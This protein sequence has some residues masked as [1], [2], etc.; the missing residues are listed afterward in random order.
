M[1]LRGNE[2][3]S[4]LGD[5][6]ADLLRT[7]KSSRHDDEGFPTYQ[8]IELRKTSICTV[9][10]VHKT[11]FTD[12]M[13]SLPN[14]VLPFYKVYVVLL[15][16]VCITDI[17]NNMMS[18]ISQS[19]N[20][21]KTSRTIR[22]GWKDDDDVRTSFLGFWALTT[23]FQWQKYLTYHILITKAITFSEKNILLI[24]QATDALFEIYHKSAIFQENTFNR[25]ATAPSMNFTLVMW[26]RRV[27]II[28]FCTVPRNNY[29][30]NKIY[31]PFD[32][33]CFHE[34]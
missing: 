8:L 10:A 18:S 22:Y 3:R 21:R 25:H 12:T 16:D 14:Y 19:A 32:F 13:Q 7:C 27:E 31:L 29:S 20:S 24:I 28:E 11:T 26:S 5:W 15:V 30:A 34:R 23:M 9:F 17:M 33:V 2:K 4:R 1:S 6:A